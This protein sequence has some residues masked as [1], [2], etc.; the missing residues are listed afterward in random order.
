MLKQTWRNGNLLQGGWSEKHI[1]QVGGIWRNITNFVIFLP[2]GN[3]IQSIW[4]LNHCVQMLIIAKAGLNFNPCSCFFNFKSSVLPSLVE[5]WQVV[6]LFCYSAVPK[7]KLKCPMHG[8]NFCMWLYKQLL[9]SWHGGYKVCTNSELLLFA[10]YQSVAL[11]PL[12]PCQILLHLEWSSVL[13]AAS[14]EL[15]NF[16]YRS[17]LHYRI[18]F[19]LLIYKFEVL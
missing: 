18:R 5:E 8:Q 2:L 15:R 13:L 4:K 11:L 1:S 7:Y 3:K 10:G 12:R 6:L 16:C 14:L 17:L 19:P 9:K